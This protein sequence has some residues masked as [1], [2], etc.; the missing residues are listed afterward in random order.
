VITVNTNLHSTRAARMMGRTRSLLDRSFSRLSSG[1]AVTS[2]R[3]NQAHF[4]AGLRASTKVKSTNYA[5]RNIASGVSLVQTAESSTR[6]LQTNV[7]RIRELA[8]QSANGTLTDDVRFSLQ[9]EVDALVE[10]INMQA[11][12][13]NEGGI[14]LLDGSAKSLNFMVGTDGGN[15]I[16]L[17]LQSLKAKDLGRMVRESGFDVDSTQGLLSGDISINGISIRGTALTDDLL[18]TA[19]QTG[20]ALAKVNAINASQHYTNV[21][22]D[23]LETLV[24]GDAIIGG[25]L[26]LNNNITING[27]QITDTLVESGDASGSL[28]GAINSVYNETGV[29]AQVDDI[30]A[31]T[32]TADDGRNIEITT[33]SNFAANA[34]GLNSGF[35]DT[36]VTGGAIQ[37][38]SSDQIELDINTLG[39]DAAVGHGTGLGT[40]YISLTPDT[41]L[42][43]ILITSQEEARRTIDITD[44]ALDTLRKQ[45]SGMGAM[46]SRLEYAMQ[47][48]TTEQ[49][50]AQ[51]TKSSMLDVDFAHEV[52][53]L[54][55]QTLAQETQSAVMAQANSSTDSALTLLDGMASLG[56]GGKSFGSGVFAS[57]SMPGIGGG[58]SFS[59]FG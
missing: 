48:I 54:T 4:N 12:S 32:L 3:D 13:A 25:Q 40:N 47:T 26:D 57:S 53:E 52:V 16:R 56:F 23:V 37:L 11:A 59:I 22:A 10:E 51:Q 19:D 1:A 18:S 46:S 55:R 41:F 29:L 7:Q 14:K 30:G 39:M 49:V 45:V 42:E 44:A 58:R 31:L 17:D 2:A 36:V 15:V 5:V 35:A 21:R 9:V 27:K 20:S 8:V 38:V 28:V 24:L 34:T 50:T 33:S 6:E 43:T